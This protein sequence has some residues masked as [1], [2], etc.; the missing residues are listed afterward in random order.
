[1]KE[2]VISKRH[3]M[4]E[5]QRST[6]HITTTTYCD[7]DNESRQNDEGYTTISTMPQTRITNLKTKPQNGKQCSLPTCTDPARKAASFK[8]R[9]N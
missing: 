8:E 3:E 1:M 2:K 7:V 6:L 9:D 5:T 4:V